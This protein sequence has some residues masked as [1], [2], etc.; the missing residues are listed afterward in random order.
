VVSED[1][2]HQ[3]WQ[4]RRDH[5]QPSHGPRGESD[6]SLAAVQYHI[7]AVRFVAL[8]AAMRPEDHRDEVVCAA[9][10]DHYPRSYGALTERYCL[11]CHANREYGIILRDAV[12][13]AGEDALAAEEAPP[14]LQ[15]RS[16]EDDCAWL[17][18]EEHRTER[19]V[20]RVERMMRGTL[21]VE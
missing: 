17:V 14:A 12:P 4:F 6:V 21:P 13:L 16:N 9:C 8:A 20:E 1:Q 19:L 2:L 18:R 5:P 7:F 11:A 3:L 10:D 15:Y